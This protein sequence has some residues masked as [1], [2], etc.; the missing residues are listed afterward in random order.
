MSTPPAA[1][2]LFLG[3][4]LE[5]PDA[6]RSAADGLAR[7]GD[8][9]DRIARRVVE[10]APLVLTGMGSSFDAVL[11][12]ASVLGRAGIPA[13]CAT[14]AELLHFRLAAIRPGS[15]VLVVSQ[16][17]LSAEAVRLAQALDARGDVTIASVTNGLENGL[18]PIADVAIDMSAGAEVGPST[19][20]FVATLVVL[21][22][23][24][25]RLGSGGDGVEL[26]DRARRAAER[27][28]TALTRAEQRGA[29]LEDWWGGRPTLVF[30]GRGA[31]LAA[32]E[33]AALVVKEAAH[34]GAFALESAEFRHGPMEM[35]GP[36][37]AVAII[38]VEPATSHLEAGLA[39]DLRRAGA[40][41]L[42][43]GAADSAVAPSRDGLVGDP[44]LDAAIATAPLLLLCWRLSTRRGD[45][46]GQ[47]RVG[48][49]TTT[50][51]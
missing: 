42:T 4:I 39:D 29:E 32:A 49:K 24:A 12:L 36:D 3:E 17:G 34:V 38:D 30:V 10:G 47:F 40:A 25:G 43:V 8:A 44:L 6:I 45:A 16:S 31:G 18:A 51:E 26:V 5:Q 9:L 11:G 21:A 13:V 33:L 50:K 14:A 37:L 19:K 1:R 20:T 7:Q 48:T 46:P 2:D 41:V 15:L 23:I 35:A 22:A 28:A 27:M